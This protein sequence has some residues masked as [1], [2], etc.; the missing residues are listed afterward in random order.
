LAFNFICALFDLDFEDLAGLTATGEDCDIPGAEG[1]AP[2]TAPAAADGVAD[3]AG[4]IAEEGACPAL[5]PGF[6]IKNE[7]ALA[8]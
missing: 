2:E 4:F 1:S 8:N 6:P 7:R 5:E 3:N